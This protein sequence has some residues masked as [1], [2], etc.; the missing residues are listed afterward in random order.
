MFG[1]PYLENETF[2]VVIPK[3]FRIKF[4]NYQYTRR[5]IFEKKI[6]PLEIDDVIIKC[7]TLHISKTGN[8]QVKVIWKKFFRIKLSFE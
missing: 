6:F 1:T 8:F 4:P 3:L 2:S 5:Y 7:L